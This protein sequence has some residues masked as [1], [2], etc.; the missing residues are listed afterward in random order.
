VK[1]GSPVIDIHIRISRRFVFWF[2]VAIMALFVLWL[3]MTALSG[4]S[5]GVEIG[6]LEPQP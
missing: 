6:P 4:G 2:V 1:D 3:I 5:G